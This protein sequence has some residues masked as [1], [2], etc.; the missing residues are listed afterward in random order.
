MTDEAES[1]SGAT[2]EASGE[3]G[4]GT[5]QQSADDQVK[6]STYQKVLTEKKNTQER[7]R[8]TEA[9]LAAFVDSQ[10]EAKENTL[11][12]QNEYKALFEQREEELKAT[13]ER[14]TNVNSQIDI[15]FKV[16]AFLGAV[17]GDIPAK[18]RS[19]IDTASIILNP[20]T[21]QVDEMSV[22]S[23]VEKFKKQYPELIKVPHKAT[24]TNVYPTGD[25]ANTGPRSISDIA[26]SGNLFS[27]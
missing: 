20:E 5:I 10:R 23:A 24:S 2:E 16:T 22:A 15:A 8:E 13:K 18:Y 4:Q 6:Y 21:K 11:K 26:L 27:K 7:L 12:E 3:P 1:T 17:D 25:A 9:K 19:F 14:L